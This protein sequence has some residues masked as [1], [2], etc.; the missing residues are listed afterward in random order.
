MR[1]AD[2]LPKLSLLL[3]AL[4]AAGAVGCGLV[5]RLP[6]SSLVSFV[7]RWKGDAR[8]L[9]RKLAAECGALPVSLELGADG[10]LGELQAFVFESGGLEVLAT[11]AGDVVPSGSLASLDLHS[12]VLPL[13]SEHAGCTKDDLQLKSKLAFDL[14]MRV[15]ALELRRE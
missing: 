14:S 13:E 10:A 2:P 11:L 5:R 12:V 8:F 9:D 15:C 6:A 1:R 4:L 3:V 7:G